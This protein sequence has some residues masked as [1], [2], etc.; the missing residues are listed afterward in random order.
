MLNTLKTVEL[1]KSFIV[2]WSNYRFLLYGMFL[3]L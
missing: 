1:F 3:I 2:N